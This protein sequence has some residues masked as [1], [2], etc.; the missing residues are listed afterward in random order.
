MCTEVQIKNTTHHLSGFVRSPLSSCLGIAREWKF[1]PPTIE[2]LIGSLVAQI[3]FR[4]GSR[5][6]GTQPSLL[7]ITA[8]CISGFSFTSVSGVLIAARKITTT[9]VE[10]L[11]IRK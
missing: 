6:I 2:F 1:S 5:K 8:P 4:V 11:A 10:I 3:G 7:T 9:A